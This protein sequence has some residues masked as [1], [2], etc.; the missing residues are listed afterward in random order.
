M[1][2]SYIT[3]THQTIGEYKITD[4][5]FNASFLDTTIDGFKSISASF[6]EKIT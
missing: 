3:P 6:N 1:S 4:T 5:L 2:N